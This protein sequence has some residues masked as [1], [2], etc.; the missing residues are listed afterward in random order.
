MAPQGDA[1]DDRVRSSARF[2]DASDIQEDCE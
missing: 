2:N 1:Q